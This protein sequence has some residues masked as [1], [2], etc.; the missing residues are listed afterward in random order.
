ME[1]IVEKTEAKSLKGAAGSADKK[2]VA[3]F[4]AGIGLVSM[5]LE[6][7]GWKT[8]YALDYDPQKAAAYTHHFGPEHYVVK[9]VATVKGREVPDVMLAH[10]SFPCTDLSVAGGRK[11]INHGESSMLWQFIRILSEMKSKY[12]RR[13]PPVIL[14]ENVEGLLTS[15]E[16]KDLESLLRALNDLNYHVDLTRI[17]AARFVPQS[18]VRIFIVGIHDSA[19]KH[20]NTHALAQLRNLTS[21]DARPKKIVDYVAQ[22]L[23]IRWYFHDLPNLPTRQSLFKDVVDVNAEWWP[24][25][26]AKFIYGQMHLRHKQLVDQ[27]LND[28]RFHYF[29]AFRRTREREGKRQSTVELRTD[30]IAGCLRTPKGG[31]ARQILVRVGKGTMDVRL[32]NEKEAACL[33]GAAEFKLNPTHDLNQVLFGFGDAVCVS[34]IEWL[35]KNYLDNLATVV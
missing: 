22:H 21:S 25:E 27:L 19:V 18:R 5:G 2:T 12:G 35:A 29:P 7:A 16:G 17:D 33:M 26:K 6:N 1:K 20:L 32:I 8:V 3:D 9:D 11:G 13:R 28:Q 15:N 14:L 30:G 34:A 4:F 10:A 24:K 23:G 31:S